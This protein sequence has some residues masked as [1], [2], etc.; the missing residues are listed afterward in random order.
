MKGDGIFGFN[1][2]YKIGKIKIYFSY[3]KITKEKINFI[4]KRT[5]LNLSFIKKIYHQ[6]HFLRKTLS[7][8]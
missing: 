8:N 2:K 3:N 1:T 5:N 6:R 7:F 4:E